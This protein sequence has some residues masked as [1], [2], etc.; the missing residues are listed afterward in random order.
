MER[1]GKGQEEGSLHFSAASD[2]CGKSF[3]LKPSSRLAFTT[4]SR[5]SVFSSLLSDCFLAPLLLLRLLPGY[6]AGHFPDAFSRSSPASGA[7]GP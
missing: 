2:K 1:G 7:P 5:S 6:K 3:F 4:I